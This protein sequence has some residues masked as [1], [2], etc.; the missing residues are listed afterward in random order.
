MN[1]RFLKKMTTHIAQDRTI[2]A[3]YTH[4]EVVAG[5]WG[6]CFNFYIRTRRSFS[7]R[8]CR[9]TREGAHTQRDCDKRFSVDNSVAPV[10]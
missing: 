7:T 9:F 3:G 5:P 2:P 6:N 10:K 8:S 1:I 4:Q